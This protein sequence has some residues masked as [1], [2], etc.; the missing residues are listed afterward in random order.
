M[1]ETNLYKL[2][3]RVLNFLRDTEGKDF[4]FDD[5]KESFSYNELITI[6]RDGNHYVKEFVN[7]LETIE[8]DPDFQAIIDERSRI[9]IEEERHGEYLNFASGDVILSAIEEFKPEN[10]YHYV[11]FLKTDEDIIRALQMHIVKKDK[12][13]VGKLVTLLK[14]DNLKL[15][16]L[17]RVSKYYYSDIISS[18]TDEKIIPKVIEKYPKESGALISKLENEDMR[19]Y[20]YERNFRKLDQYSKSRIFK[21][22]TEENKVKYLNR[23]WKHFSSEEKVSH[24]A[25]IKNDELLLEKITQLSDIEKIKLID[26]LS[27]NRIE[28]IDKIES[29][30]TYKNSKRLIKQI[31]KNNIE[32]AIEYLNVD[33]LMTSTNDKRKLKIIEENSYYSYSIISLA[34]VKKFKSI[35][36]YLNHADGLPHYDE[37]FNSL[38]SR[39]AEEYK[40]NPEHLIKIIKLTGL[41]TLKNIRSEKL[42][43]IINLDEK[44][45]NKIIGLLDI[46]KHK[47]DINT[48]NDNINIYLQRSFR[49][50]NPDI[51]NISSHIRLAIQNN[52]QEQALALMDKIVNEFDISKILNK[53][54][55]TSAEFLKKLVEKTNPDQEI[56]SCLLEITNEYIGYKRNAFLKENMAIYQRTFSI[57]DYDVKSAQKFIIENF[58]TSFIK[59]VI[60][61]ENRFGLENGASQEEI[62]LFNHPTALET[63]IQFR[64]NPLQFK[65][66]PEDAKKYM[67]TFNKLFEKNFKHNLIHMLPTDDVK[68]TYK[69]NQYVDPNMVREVLLDLDVDVLKQGILSNDELYQTLEKTL[70][71]YK[72]YGF[73]E[74]MRSTFSNADLWL[75]SSTLSSLIN[76]FPVVYEELKEKLDKG[77]IKNITLPAILDLAQCYSMSS[78]KLAMVFGQDNIRLISSNPGPNSASWSKE[79]R[80]E[81]AQKYL[82]AMYER[83]N[84]SIPPVDEDLELANGKKMNVVIGNVTDPINLTYGERTGACMRIGGHAD[85]LFDFCLKDDNGF[86]IRFSSPDDDGFVSRVSGF[87]NGNTIFLNELRFSADGR[88]TNDDVREACALAAQLLIERSKD[89]SSPIENVVIA[90]EYVMSGEKRIPLNVSD[91]KKGV[92]NF[93]TDVTSDNATILATSNPDNSL[94]PIKLGNGGVQKYQVQRGKVR[95]YEGEK[96]LEHIDRIEIIDQM[97]SGKPIDEAEPK[98]KKDIAFCYCGEDWYVTIDTKGN[99]G[100]YIM[101]SSNKKELANREKDACV[102]QLRERLGHSNEDTNTNSVG[103][104]RR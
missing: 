22:L 98:P 52:E 82:K 74:E 47:M 96:C 79:K 86:H 37:R 15:K 53:H 24:L 78:N 28:L 35:E 9:C 18:I 43:K 44:D 69:P 104:V 61:N 11:S 97:L 54:N 56:V 58:P 80:I 62:E 92:G 91:V 48:L 10:I 65:G 34:T 4:S 13:A 39:Y 8:F 89:S 1:D 77:E 88:Y 103:G 25:S 100:E 30:I 87:R 32:S 64:R 90:P 66:M 95:M 60:F 5:V 38:I 20:Y 67:T 33:K 36:K 31:L 73:N 59:K 26:C 49:L 45:F 16:Y 42:Q 101:A 17:S 57:A 27:K 46:E 94:V 7:K 102:A 76:Y 72:L 83:K 75:D 51:I 99:V 85:S 3:L 63:I 29:S 71:R 84:I 19:I 70:T 81:K 50:Q 2:N 23:Y 55:L 12:D 93:Y 68:M 40:L 6:L 21:T 14:D 41:E